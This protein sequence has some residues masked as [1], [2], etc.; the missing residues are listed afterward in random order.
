VKI[1]KQKSARD[2]VEKYLNK[3]S[4]AQCMKR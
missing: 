1:F 3:I 4:I 2:F